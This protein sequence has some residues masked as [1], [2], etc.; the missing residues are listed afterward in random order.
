LSS[1]DSR[2]FAGG[3]RSVQTQNAQR[4]LLCPVSQIVAVS[5]KYIFIPAV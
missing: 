5:H 3:Q 1:Y 4:K 2:F